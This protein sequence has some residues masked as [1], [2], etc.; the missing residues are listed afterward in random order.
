LFAPSALLPQYIKALAFYRPRLS[1]LLFGC[2]ILFLAFSAKLRA[3]YL[4]F[5]GTFFSVSSG[6]RG[7]SGKGF[8]FLF[9]TVV[10][11]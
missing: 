5:A 8:V 9:R 10:L 3:N 6:S 1:G 2:L 7:F 11:I 4:S